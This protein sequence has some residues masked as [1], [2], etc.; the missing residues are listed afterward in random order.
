MRQEGRHAAYYASGARDL[1]QERKAQNV[2]KWFLR[3]EWAP[4]G[5]GDVPRI[6]TSFATAYLFGSGEGAELID[7]VEE[8]IDAL[9]GL[10]GLDLV[11][12][13]IVAATRHVVEVEGSVPEPRKYEW[14]RAEL[15]PEL[16]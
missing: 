1:L 4:V 12:S 8:R 13:A 5:S 14:T 9:P 7:R 16:A 6:E 11:R 3:H 10:N 15:E 2:T